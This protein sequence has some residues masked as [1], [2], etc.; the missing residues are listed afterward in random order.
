MFVLLNEI[1][2]KL[3]STALIT[4]GVFVLA[5]DTNAALLLSVNP[6]EGGSSLRFGR[7]DLSEI[8]NKEVRIRINSNEGN[9]YQVFQRIVES[10]VNE[11]GVSLDY[12][13]LTS[14]T[15]IGSNTAGTLYQ[16][17]EE[18]LGFGEQLIYS[19]NPNGDSDAFTIVYS[20]KSDRLN[21]SG[22]FLGKIQ[23][24]LRPIGG[25]SQDNVFLNIV[26]E[27]NRQ[28]SLSTETS[29]GRNLVRLSFKGFKDNEG[30]IKFS[31]D[32]SLGQEVKV[33]QEIVQF[34]INELSEDF[35]SEA[36]QFMVSSAGNGATSFQGPGQL[37]RKKIL[38]YS[39]QEARD[40]FWVNFT[41]GP[42]QLADQKAGLY[43]GK[44]RYTVESEKRQE[45]VDLDL[46]VEV[47]PVFKLEVEYP[48]EGVY[49]SHLLPM[50]P[51]QTKEINVVVKTNLGKPFMV[52]QNVSSPLTSEQGAKIPEE[53]F[54]IKQELK[55]QAAGKIE[56]PEFAPV[57]TGETPIFFS[58][59]KGSSA[60]FKVI[61]R[62]RPFPEIAAGD[63]STAIVYSLGEI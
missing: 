54:S 21:S 35:P 36:I 60:Q 58:D 30:Y 39:S 4:V 46:E 25:N 16:N 9:Q 2:G 37:P 27:A 43:R 45:V 63:Y 50:A 10:P 44:I 6:L 3:L 41:S 57:P 42:E 34:P 13:A 38:L 47:S 22:N 49:F 1:R 17:D 32:G 61:Y 20:V 7:V 28:L 19:S 40:E 62:L 33:Y 11:Q 18:S 24:T 51:P 5:T 53:F 14:F 8:S 31:I 48:P 12:Q 29:S 55:E 52:T 26:L 23:Y 59:N 56:F 15:L